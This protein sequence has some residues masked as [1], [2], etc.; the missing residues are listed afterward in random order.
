SLSLS[1]QLD[2][3]RIFVVGGTLRGRAITFAGAADPGR[4]L[5]IVR[6]IWPEA[7]VGVDGKLKLSGELNWGGGGTATVGEAQ[8]AIT[9]DSAAS[10][11][12]VS[13]DKLRLTSGVF[14][15]SA[16]F[17]SETPVRV[18]ASGVGL[19]MQDHGFTADGVAG[20]IAL[21]SFSPL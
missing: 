17:A 15:V 18:R 21:A 12:A 9:P 11:P 16:D 4:T 19:A 5:L 1:L 10:E 13:E 3:E 6:S 2:Q 20:E 7:L 8:I 14:H